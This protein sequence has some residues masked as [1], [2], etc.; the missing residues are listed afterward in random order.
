MQAAN[1]AVGLWLLASAASHQQCQYAR[2]SEKRDLQR[3]VE[4]VTTKKKEEEKRLR[5]AQESYRQLHEEQAAQRK[6]ERPWWK[7]W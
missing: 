2:R 1:W 5:E 4:I 3:H 6:R 7:V